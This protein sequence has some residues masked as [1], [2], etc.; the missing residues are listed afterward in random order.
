MHGIHVMPSAAANQR[1]GANEYW[2]FLWVVVRNEA[3]DLGLPGKNGFAFR[4]TVANGTVLRYFEPMMFSGSRRP[5]WHEVL[6]I[7]PGAKGVVNSEKLAT[8]TTGFESLPRFQTTTRLPS[9]KS[10]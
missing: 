2:A 4:S 10:K 6:C 8:T 3:V 1:S 7:G 9:L 5:V